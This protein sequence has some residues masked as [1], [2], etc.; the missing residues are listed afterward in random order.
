MIPRRFCRIRKAGQRA[1]IARL[2]EGGTVILPRISPT[3]ICTW[4]AVRLSPTTVSSSLNRNIERESPGVS[5]SMTI[6]S[7]L[8]VSPDVKT[9]TLVSPSPLRGSGRRQGQEWNERTEARPPVRRKGWVRPAASLEQA[10]SRR[11]A[12]PLPRPVR[13]RSRILSSR[14]TL[15]EMK[16]GENRWNCVASIPA[17]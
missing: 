12:P 3:R 17:S 5:S 4:A 9:L 2:P 6:R 16:P 11:F 14:T 8:L 7:T 13:P 1:Y 10:E 15:D